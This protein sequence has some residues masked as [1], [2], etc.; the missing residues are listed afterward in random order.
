MGT[1]SLIMVMV[2]NFV[3]M[4]MGYNLSRMSTSA[5]RKYI[6]YY[7]I[8]QAQCVTASAANIAVSK[9]YTDGTTDSHE[10]DFTGGH[11]S[12]TQT[13]FEDTLIKLVVD[14]EYQGIAG[15]SEVYLARPSFSTYAM[16][17]IRENGIYW[18][19]GDTC[20]GP[21]HTEDYLYISGEPVFEGYVTTY[22]GK[23]LLGTCNPHFIGGY[24]QGFSQGMPSG[25]DDAINFGNNGGKKYSANNVWFDF[26]PDGQVAVREAAGSTPPAMSSATVYHDI[27][28]LTAN[29]VVLVQGK[30]AHVKGNLNGKVTI[31]CVGTGSKIWIDSSITYQKPPKIWDAVQGKEVTNPEC[32]DM[33]GLLCDNDITVKLNAEDNYNAPKGV[34]IHASMMSKNAG[35]GFGAENYDSR[36]VGGKLTVVG[37]IQQYDRKAVGKFSGGAIIHGFQK[38]YNYDERLK[39]EAP[40]GYPLLTKFRVRNWYEQSFIP[41]KVWEDTTYNY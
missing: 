14:A 3:F 5:Y 6:S 10:T 41:K 31:G 29:G 11:F 8:E 33:L 18:I 9:V 1:K 32:D 39:F 15:R 7:D 38:N 19:T 13:A 40:K 2:F 22:K 23:K 28:E 36:V 34:T 35:S 12:I 21:L 25:L 24:E 26:Y 17:S 27:D 30:E 37:G 16:F 4:T 20:R